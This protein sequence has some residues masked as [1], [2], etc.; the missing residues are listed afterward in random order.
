M[1]LRKKYTWKALK[2]TGKSL[3]GQKRMRE[4]SPRLDNTGIFSIKLVTQFLLKSECPEL[5][6]AQDY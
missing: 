6:K 4:M 2:Q 1:N 5:I 3:Y